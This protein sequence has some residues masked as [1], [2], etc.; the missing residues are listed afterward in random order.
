MIS[1][2]DT[3]QE[4]EAQKTRR[5]YMDRLHEIA[6]GSAGAKAAEAA[7]TVADP[8][9]EAPPPETSVQGAESIPQSEAATETLGTSM[10]SDSEPFSFQ[11]KMKVEALTEAT[12]VDSRKLA[13]EIAPK[14]VDVFV[15]TFEEMERHS[16]ASNGAVSEVVAEMNRVSQHLQVLSGQMGALRRSIDSMTASQQELSTRV[17][18]I[19][20]GLR[21]H[22]KVYLNLEAS[23]KQSEQALRA[24]QDLLT[25]KLDSASAEAAQINERL[26]AQAGAIR[27]LHESSRNREDHRDELRSALL[28]IQ[29]LASKLSTPEPLPDKL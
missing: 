20:A 26:D 7:T 16:S 4:D 25:E 24:Q 28:A 1:L 11:G 29:D 18:N 13:E 10:V 8:P 15:A 19:E 17:S 6:Y 3:K 14:F 2:F 12:A 22:E 23:M 9:G 5:V 21:E 27:A